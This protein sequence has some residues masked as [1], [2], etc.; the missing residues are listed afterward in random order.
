MERD[1]VFH[2]CMRRGDY[3]KNYQDL[4]E[5]ELVLNEELQTES[6]F[7]SDMFQKK[8]HWIPTLGQ[9]FVLQF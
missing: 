2:V 5:I 8:K 1:K 7:A 3:K 4:E 6:R 9:D